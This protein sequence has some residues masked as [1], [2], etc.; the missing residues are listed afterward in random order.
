MNIIKPSFP[1]WNAISINMSMICSSFKLFFSVASPSDY[2]QHPYVNLLQQ[3][4]PE[5]AP[6]LETSELLVWVVRGGVF[7]LFCDWRL[8]GRNCRWSPQELL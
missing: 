2:S 4:G 7:L 6:V 1:K 5:I 3:K 8:C